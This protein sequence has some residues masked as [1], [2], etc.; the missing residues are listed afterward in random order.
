VSL[1]EPDIPEREV[2]IWQ[3]RHQFDAMG[4]D[5][6]VRSGELYVEILDETRAP[7]NLQAEI[8]LT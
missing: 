3:L 6:R 8:V 5:D 2:C 7:P 4:L 1:D